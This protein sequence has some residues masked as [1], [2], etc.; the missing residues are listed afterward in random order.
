MPKP[1][2]PA[3]MFEFGLTLY[4]G[5]DKDTIS[6]PRKFLEVVDEQTNQVLQWMHGGATGY[7]TAEFLFDRTGTFLPG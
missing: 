7:W 3:N 6:L 5:C 2:E 1:D 4:Y